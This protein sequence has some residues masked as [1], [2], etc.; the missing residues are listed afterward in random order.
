M[1]QGIAAVST[2][3]IP[4]SPD[5]VPQTLV[6]TATLSPDAGSATVEVHDGQD[7]VALLTLSGTD[8]TPFAIP[9]PPPEADADATVLEVRT[10]LPFDD[11]YCRGRYTVPEVRL[12]GLTVEVDD[13]VRAA[14]DRG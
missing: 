8:P 1:L 7:R 5:L 12:S 14:H 4:A 10:Y 3:T 13:C 11:S 6:G 9:L 2:V